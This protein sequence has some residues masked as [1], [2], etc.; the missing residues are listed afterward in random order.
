MK[1]HHLLP[2]A[3]V[4]V[5]MIGEHSH[6]APLFSD[7]FENG[8]GKWASNTRDSGTISVV[9]EGCPQSQ[10]CVRVTN[11]DRNSYVYIGR[12]FIIQRPGS[13]SFGAKIRVPSL[14][15]G[16]EFFHVAKF[17]AAIIRDGR[18]ISWPNS[19]IYSPVAGWRE[20]RFKALDLKSGDEVLLRIGLQNA[21]G[22]IEVDDVEVAFVP[23]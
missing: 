14:V 19:D 8:L 4:I 12:K 15:K 5:A 17:Q 20:R 13:L 2:V 10:K 3:L 21:K 9:A 22:T 7:N 23:D 1:L 11:D 6:A 16:A 18:E